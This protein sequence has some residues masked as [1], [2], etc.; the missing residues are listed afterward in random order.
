MAQAEAP[1]ATAAN[2]VVAFTEYS[3]CKGYRIIVPKQFSTKDS[4]LLMKLQISAIDAHAVSGVERDTIVNTAA[5]TT[6]GQ[7]CVHINFC[8]VSRDDFNYPAFCPLSLVEKCGRI[9]AGVCVVSLGQCRQLAQRSKHL[10]LDLDN[11]LGLLLERLWPRR[12]TN[13]VHDDRQ[14]RAIN[15]RFESLEDTSNPSPSTTSAICS[16]STLTTTTEARK[17]NL[18]VITRRRRRNSNDCAAEAPEPKRAYTAPT[19]RLSSESVFRKPTSS[20]TS[21]V[22]DRDIIHAPTAEIGNLTPL[23]ASTSKADMMVCLGLDNKIHGLL[24]KEAYQARDLIYKSLG[25]LSW[26]DLPVE[27]R[28][29]ATLGMVKNAS[30]ET[31]PYYEKGR[32]CN[33]GIEENWVAW[34]YLY[35]CFRYKLRNNQ[36]NPV[37]LLDPLTYLGRA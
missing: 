29:K 33:N 24:L 26:K 1:A 7:P 35:S 2:A 17:D 4:K 5:W 9:V 3:G 36:F 11:N 23:P 22:P 15:M 25:H 16:Q 32:W 12:N 30:K 37:T 18:G 21:T 31:K 14:V 20:S 6:E 27:V 19:F 28:Q 13:L 34:W 8:P 10:P